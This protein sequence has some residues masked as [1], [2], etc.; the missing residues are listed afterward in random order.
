VKVFI[1]WSGERS[2]MMAEALRGWLPLVLYYV[3]PWVSGKDIQAGE[4]W[5]LEVG[6]ELE[7]SNF[8]I[9]CLTKDNLDAGWML[10]EAGARCAHTSWTQNFATSQDHYHN[11]NPKEQTRVRR[12]NSCRR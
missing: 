6:K 7:E 10:F 8:G 11:S 4:R 5:S 12:S 9:L 3:K 2:W 1:S